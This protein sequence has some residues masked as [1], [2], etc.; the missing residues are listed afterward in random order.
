FML[1]SRFVICGELPLGAGGKLDRKAL[2]AI[3]ERPELQTQGLKEPEDGLE[4]RLREI[5]RAAFA[6]DDIGASDDFFELGGHSLLASTI[7]SALNREF[8]LALRPSALLE[9]PTIRQLAKAIGLTKTVAESSVV[10]IHSGG[11]RPPFFCVHGIGGEV[12]TFRLL[13]SY[14]GPDQPFFAMRA[15]RQAES[16]APIEDIAGRYVRDIR[17]IDPSGPYYLGG[18]SFGGIIAFEMAHQLVSAGHDVALV[19][20]IDAYA[21]GYPRPHSVLR[22]GLLSVRAIWRAIPGTRWNLVRNKIIIN[23]TAARRTVGA[24]AYRFNA[25]TLPPASTSG[26]LDYQLYVG[27][28]TRARYVL[29]PYPGRIDLFRAADNR[30]A[31]HADYDNGWGSAASGGLVVHNI[32]GDHFTLVADPNVAT[33]AATLSLRIDESFSGRPTEQPA[34]GPWKQ[35]RLPSKSDLLKVR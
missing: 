4:R 12:F 20:L 34:T 17:R 21:P 32:P 19:A 26:A 3:A 35:D 5:W 16:D 30:P 28:R 23:L 31:F 14:L 7:V 10:P 11:S 15:L 18:Y 1:P 2:Q 6:R 25:D 24:Y 22:R 29:R 13:A 9:A 27:R 33:L 8:G